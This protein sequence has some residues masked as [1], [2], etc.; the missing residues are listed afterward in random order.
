M[1]FLFLPL[2]LILAVTASGKPLKITLP[3]ETAVYK[4]GPGAELANAQ[5]MTCHS[6]DYAAM[7]PPKPRD[8]WKAE[9]E[10]MKG[11]YGAPYST[12]D[13]DGLIGYFAN[14]YGTDTNV[15]V[16]PTIAPAPVANGI[17]AKELAIKSGCFNCHQISSK[18]IGPAYKDV[19]AKYRNKSDAM[20]KVAHQITHG[21]SGQWGPIPMP[22]FTQFSPAEV[23]ALGEWILSLK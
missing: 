21:G 16:M 8:F 1:K 6:A 13:F 15:V 3:V 22:P 17:N 2:S 12:N 4:A 5:C 19:A 18:L 23:K 14:N 20:A 10:K 11:K 7:Q 9:V